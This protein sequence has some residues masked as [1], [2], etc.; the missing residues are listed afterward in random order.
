M[1]DKFNIGMVLIKGVME[2]RRSFVRDSIHDPAKKLTIH[3]NYEARDCILQTLVG[4]DA[5]FGK[6]D[7]KSDQGLTALMGIPVIIH[8]DVTIMNI[9]EEA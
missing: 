4:Q 2:H 3:L 7:L 8:P 5:Q 6:V 1:A 9:L